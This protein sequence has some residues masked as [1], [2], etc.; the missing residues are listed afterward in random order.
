[1]DTISLYNDDLESLANTLDS[2]NKLIN[3]GNYKTLSDNIRLA[4]CDSSACEWRLFGDRAVK[5]LWQNF[6]IQAKRQRGRG[7]P[8]GVTAIAIPER[9]GEALAQAFFDNFAE[10][11]SGKEKGQLDL[12]KRIPALK[13]LASLGLN[14]T[15]DSFRI[16]FKSVKRNNYQLRLKQG[17][18]WRNFYAARATFSFQGGDE[19]TMTR[20]CMSYIEAKLR[21]RWYGIETEA[22]ARGG[23]LGYGPLQ[24]VDGVVL[25]RQSFPDCDELYLAAIE[26]KV[27]NEAQSLF[28][29]LRQAASYKAFANE[30]WIVAPGLGVSEYHD[31]AQHEQFLE[32]CREHGFGVMTVQ[33]GENGKKVQG[34][35]PVLAPKPENIKVPTLLSDTLG[36]AG[37][38]RCTLCR[39]YYLNGDE[40]EGNAS[41]EPD[42]PTS[43]GWKNP[44]G[45]CM[46]S[47]LER[48]TLRDASA[49]T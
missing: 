38:Q 46:R 6:G 30:V 19:N 1:M 36:E 20:L 4:V 33:L 47:A 42:A 10:P 23:K 31:P 15:Y 9:I 41:T 49:L 39:R 25:G 34:V 17:Q 45:A 28:G 26:A 37:W 7:G 32:S 13:K 27:N 12:D 14:I 5:A 2:D 22:A 29:A 43:C 18:G 44:K 40:A 48:V 21:E 8:L 35:I 24:N 11:I 16:G 3:S